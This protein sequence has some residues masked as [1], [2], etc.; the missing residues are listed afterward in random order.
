MRKRILLVT[1]LVSVLGIVLL[2]VLFSDVFYRQSIEA[3]AKR[4]GGPMQEELATLLREYRLGVDLPDAFERMYR[5]MPCEDLHLLVTSI[6]LTTRSGG[7]LVEVLEELVSTIRSRTEFQERLKNMTAQGRFEALAISLA[8]VA[9][10]VLLYLI[11]PG[12]MR[13]LVTTGWGWLAVTGAATL[14]FTGYYILKKI[15]TIEV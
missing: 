2:S 3:V 12:L 15:V 4:I 6:S 7:S 11:D 1:L 10:F 8:P 14:V 5:R 13:P 9:A